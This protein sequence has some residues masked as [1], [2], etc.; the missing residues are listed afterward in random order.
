MATKSQ[1]KKITDDAIIAMYM[2]YVLEHETVPRSI[3]KFCKSNKIKEEDF[4]NFFGSIEGIQVAVWEKFYTNTK[5]IMNSNVAYASF[6][7]KDKM[8]TFF[9]S[10]FELL[11]MNRSYVLFALHEHKNILKNLSQLKG[12]RTH[13]KAFAADLIEKGNADK[14][15][16][17]TKKNPK[18][19][20]EGAWFQ[21]MFLLKFWMDDSS[22]GFEK[23]DLAIEK[24]VHTVFDVFENTPLESLIDFGKFLY[25]ENFA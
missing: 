14:N 9:F 12:L 11:T 1:T 6:S 19:F 24:S 21:F 2:E 16:K 18:I 10:M 15:Y 13:I 20:S 8:L 25:K 3:Y 5:A 7:N 22:A 17:L 4:Y 23:T